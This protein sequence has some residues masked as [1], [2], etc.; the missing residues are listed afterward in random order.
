[1]AQK[2]KLHSPVGAEPLILK[3][4][5]ATSEGKEGP[6][7]IVDTIRLVCDDFS[8]LKTALETKI[9][10]PGEDVSSYDYEQ[11]KSL[12]ERY[13]KAIEGIRQ[14]MKG[15][16]KQRQFNK[17]AS[18]MQLKHIL[19][20]CYNHSVTDPE[21]LNH[22]EPFSPEVY[23]ETSFELVEQMIKSVKFTE[24]D[25]FIDLGSGVGQV[26]LQVSAATN[27]K[28][29]Y[30]VEK[31]EWPAEYAVGMEREFH[32]WMKW[33]GKE[34][35]DFLIEKGDFLHDDVK[36]KLN[37]ATIVFVNNFA[38]GPV[39]DHELKQRFANC[40]KEGARIVSSKAFCPLNFRITERNLSDI[41]TIMTVEELSP[42]CGA[43]SWTGKPF[44]YYVHTIDR[45]L[46]EKYFIRLKNPAKR[47]ELEPR[48]DRKGRPV[49]SIKEKI[50]G[51]LSA[52]SDSNSNGRWRR[53]RGSQRENDS[54]P[55]VTAAKVLDFDSN[56][57]SSFTNSTTNSAVT[58][59]SG[60]VIFGPTTRRQWNEYVKKPQSQSG[61][62]NDNDSSTADAVTE[63]KVKE[64]SKQLKQKKKRMKTVKRLNNGALGMRQMQVG[65]KP[66]AETSAVKSKAAVKLRPRLNRNVAKKGSPNGPAPIL[67]TSGNQSPVTHTISSSPVSM[68]SSVASSQ[69]LD[70]LN[71][72]HAHTIMSTSGKDPTEQVCYN[73]KRMT[74][75]S[76][77]YFKPTVQQQTV[78]MLE[79]QAGV[80]QYFES[81][82][83]S[84][85]S[86]L[87]FMQTPQYKAILLLQIEQEKCKNAEL[88]AKTEG[89]EKE[90]SMLQRDGVKLIKDRLKEMGIKADTP[91]ELISQ[92]KDIVL[93]HHELKSQ[94]ASLGAQINALQAEH[95]QKITAYKNVMDRKSYMHPNK[96]GLTSHS[97]MVMDKDQYEQRKLLADVDRLYT[98]LQFLQDVNRKYTSKMDFGGYSQLD[99]NL[100]HSNKQPL[101]NGVSKSAGIT[102]LMKEKKDMKEN[103]DTFD[104][105]LVTLKR[106]VTT[107]LHNGMTRSSAVRGKIDSIPKQESDRLIKGNCLQLPLSVEISQ[108]P[109]VGVREF[110]PKPKKSVG[111][112]FK[113]PS[114]SVKEVADESKTSLH[115]SSPWIPDTMEVASVP[116]CNS[117]IL[118]PGTKID[119]KKAPKPNGVKNLLRG[120]ITE[121]INFTQLQ[122]SESVISHISKSNALASSVSSTSLL[123][124]DIEK[125][126]AE[127]LISLKESISSP[128]KDKA[129]LNHNATVI[130]PVH[131][132]H[133]QREIIVSTQKKGSSIYS[134][135]SSN[136]LNDSAK[137]AIT[138][139]PEGMVNASRISHPPSGSILS[140]GF[141]KQSLNVATT[142]SE[143]AVSQMSVMCNMP[144]ANGYLK[145][146][147]SEV[148]I[149]TPAKIRSIDSRNDV[150][151]SSSSTPLQLGQVFQSMQTPMSSLAQIL[152]TSAEQSRGATGGSILSS[153]LGHIVSSVSRGG[154]SVP[155]V[156]IQ[157]PHV[158]AVPS[159]QTTNGLQPALLKILQQ[160]LLL[161]PKPSTGSHGSLTNGV[162]GASLSLTSQVQQNSSESLGHTVKLLDGKGCLQSPLHNSLV[163]TELD[164]DVGMA[165]DEQC[166]LAPSTYK[167][168]N[169][170]PSEVDILDS[171]LYVG[172]RQT[173]SFHASTSR[174][175]EP[176]A[177]ILT[178]LEGGKTDENNFIYSDSLHNDME[179]EGC[180]YKSRKSLAVLLK[181]EAKL[182]KM[183]ETKSEIEILKNHS[184]NSIN[185]KK[186]NTSLIDVTLPTSQCEH[187]L[188]AGASGAQNVVCME[189]Q[190]NTKDSLES[191][192]PLEQCNDHV[193]CAVNSKNG[194]I[195]K[196]LGSQ[197]S[198]TL[199]EDDKHKKSS[200]SVSLHHKSGVFHS[201]S[202]A[203]NDS[204]H[205]MNQDSSQPQKLEKTY[206]ND[207]KAKLRQSKTPESSIT[208][209]DQPK[210]RDWSSTSVKKQTVSKVSKSHARHSK[211]RDLSPG[212]PKLERAISP[213]VLRRRSVTDKNEK[214]TD[215]SNEKVNSNFHNN[216]ESKKHSHRSVQR[217]N[218]RSHSKKHRSSSPVRKSRSPRVKER[219]SVSPNHNKRHTIDSLFHKGSHMSTE[220]VRSSSKS[221]D[222]TAIKSNSRH[223]SSSSFRSKKR[224]NAKNYNADK[225]K[226][227][228]KKSPK[229]DSHN[230]EPAYSKEKSISAM[231]CNNSQALKVEHSPG[232]SSSQQV[233]PSE[234]IKSKQENLDHPLIQLSH[235]DSPD[236]MLTPNSMSANGDTDSADV[237]TFCS[238]D[239]SSKQC[240]D[241]ILDAC[242]NKEVVTHTFPD[243]EQ[244]SLPL[245]P[246]KTPN[247][248]PNSPFTDT[249][250]MSTDKIS[251]DTTLSQQE[252]HQTTKA[253]EVAVEEPPSQNI[254]KGPHT[255]P[256][257]PLFNH[258][259][260]SRYPSISSSSSRG[261]SYD[262][263]S[264]SSSYSDSSSDDTKK[265]KRR[266]CQ[267]KVKKTPPRKLSTLN[268][269]INLSIGSPPIATVQYSPMPNPSVTGFNYNQ[270]R[271]GPGCALSPLSVCTQQS[272][273]YQMVTSDTMRSPNLL[274]SPNSSCTQ[275]Q[276]PSLHTPL[277][278]PNSAVSSSTAHI[279]HSGNIHSNDTKT[280]LDTKNNPDFEPDLN[281]ENLED[282]LKRITN[283]SLSRPNSLDLVTSTIKEEHSSV[284]KVKNVAVRDFETIVKDHNANHTSLITSN[285]STTTALL[286]P[287]SVK[288]RK[289]NTVSPVVES[290]FCATTCE[291][292]SVA[293]GFVEPCSPQQTP[294]VMTHMKSFSKHSGVDSLCTKDVKEV[295]NVDL[296]E[297]QFYS[298]SQQSC[299]HQQQQHLQPSYN[300]HQPSKILP[301]QRTQLPPSHGMPHHFHSH[302]LQPPNTSRLGFAPRSGHHL[303]QWNSIGPHGHTPYPHGGLPRFN[304][305]RHPL[306]PPGHPTGFRDPSL[307]EHSHT[308]KDFNPH[309][310]VDQSYGPDLRWIVVMPKPTK[311]GQ[312]AVSSTMTNPQ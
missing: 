51:A 125:S 113:K 198:Q 127:D 272:S 299:N 139:S 89:L 102:H 111:Q 43:V 203:L 31:A 233:C 186:C 293:A 172:R 244:F 171:K 107:A 82:K 256:G 292:M 55:S 243:V 23:G 312:I 161:P 207:L 269:P 108:K 151:T 226:N 25:Y 10:K 177:K 296:I 252:S 211:E 75:T 245:T 8:E 250:L 50:N 143:R 64:V 134:S 306:R 146:K 170:D 248:C 157:S 67:A 235:L 128:S 47:D 166:S 261:S 216:Q 85:L 278:S 291:K 227:K 229:L 26:I 249:S 15:S 279:T 255:P 281:S 173:R 183:A 307:A 232:M 56:S 103:Y 121:N 284:Y 7:E 297:P 57:N 98:E 189:T 14:L 144:L 192:E 29:C 93:Q 17:R 200:T 99:H 213:P 61:T 191:D 34:H 239:G 21:K 74:E 142:S 310:A 24:S 265:R 262:S 221:S 145:H 217:C 271:M 277:L 114:T 212:P 258:Q 185:N 80:L 290:T 35:G 119:I 180:T 129:T 303:P 230:E 289:Y 149:N 16:A 193:D 116:N 276:F 259:S 176:Y 231:M 197:T 72:L 190:N 71:L 224:S 150:K 209:V 52:G 63:T 94:T 122:N 3:W 18:M 204:A 218:S 86:F 130:T 115:V 44:A 222:K 53:V 42:L 101:P 153:S 154:G 54:P 120:K 181:R 138:S 184:L 92:A 70:S 308:G 286:S 228:K 311:N 106:E 37:K 263:S 208:K 246:Q 274:K 159:T 167:C 251:E 91:R 96:N 81:F 59:D 275:K 140:Q 41:G 73:D 87:A 62:E 126:A 69:P 168:L 58:E 188:D 273:G 117:R 169:E 210:R 155:F 205:Q 2:L 160:P 163:V 83:Q 219:G 152:T 105:V 287:C 280:S 241:D 242:L 49:L 28:F 109:I 199:L 110:E 201:K 137:S 9:L 6:E 19:Q 301:V 60:T 32:R 247:S 104:E 65:K 238:E 264:S 179:M 78:S 298:F 162:T 68:A 236:S 147:S 305:T 202:R 195:E 187:V 283:V 90:I 257:S 148:A 270:L 123:Y 100:N 260:R 124:T 45:T 300:H 165:Q 40:L 131:R 76:S 36:E 88:L 48:K 38:F 22:Y 156:T 194:N 20:Q 175:C 95:N 11:T 79:K 253:M 135:S 5:V 84:L 4:P 266:R 206:A 295:K 220:S 182:E 223:S 304:K 112:P 97:N 118:P 174:A 254:K 136:N 13:N 46:L 288:N 1:M 282:S 214:T 141:L 12:C 158:N 240:P 77:A 30:G 196:T 164:V 33:Y 27:C 234:F 237:M 309:G 267:D 294:S 133:S 302:G 66:P 225:K 268:P 215:L 285:S 178:F 132:I 39:V